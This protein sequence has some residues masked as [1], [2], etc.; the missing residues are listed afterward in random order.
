M[1]ERSSS[2][3]RRTSRRHAPG[4]PAL[5]G[6]PLS[7]RVTLLGF[8]IVALIGVLS[9]CGNDQETSSQQIFPQPSAAEPTIAVPE[10]SYPAKAIIVRDA[11]V[12]V[13]ANR[14]F[15]AYSF[16]DDS[17]RLDVIARDG[18]STSHTVKKG[19][20]FMA[21]DVRFTV[22]DVVRN[23]NTSGAAGGSTAQ[24]VLLPAS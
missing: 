1:D 17:G 3:S 22:L 24:I 23:T 4:Q 12:T 13:W 9:A 21:D 15:F 19:D 6:R 20:T 16:R 2:V 18:T 10:A 5:P 8:V 11:L 7:S 14:S